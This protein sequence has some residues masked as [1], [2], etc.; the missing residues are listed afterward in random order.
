[1]GRSDKTCICCGE[2]YKFCLHCSE[3]DSLP[4]WM[5]I[6]HNEN[7]K[8]LFN[9]TTEYK[10][11]NISAQEAKER[12]DKCDLSYKYKL[13]KS[14]VDAINEVN[15]SNKKKSKEKIVVEEIIV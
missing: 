8:K 10:T 11:K 1:M 4:R 3:Y 5:N 14:I 12:Y 7:C 15:K 9:I 2:K 13:H 6:Y